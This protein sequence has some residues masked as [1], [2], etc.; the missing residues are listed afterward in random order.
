MFYLVTRNCD[1]L[2]KVR[3]YV[4]MTHDTAICCNPPMHIVAGDWKTWPI[5]NRWTLK[6]IMFLWKYKDKQFVSGHKILTEDGL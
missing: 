4:R 1:F 6:L 3:V 2:P 5:Q